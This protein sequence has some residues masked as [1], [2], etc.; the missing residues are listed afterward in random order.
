MVERD[1]AFFI[2]H[3]SESNALEKSVVSWVGN[4]DLWPAHRASEDIDSADPRAPYNHALEQSWPFP[5]GGV[6]VYKECL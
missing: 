4:Q 5:S 6:G 2:S 1:G 3:F